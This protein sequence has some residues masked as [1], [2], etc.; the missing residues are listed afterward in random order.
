MNFM[1][2]QKVKFSKQQL[3]VTFLV[4]FC[5]TMVFFE[6]LV[7]PPILPLMAKELALS[8]AQAGSYMT[9]FFIGYFVSNL[10]GG[11]IT[12]RFGYKKT[13]MGVLFATGL[14]TGLMG[15]ANSY[16]MGFVIR[17]LS[18]IVAGAATSSVLRAV[19]EWFPDKGRGTAVGF[20][21]TGTSTGLLIVN[22]FIP[23]I[24]R[25]YGLQTAFFTAGLLNL[26]PLVLVWL[27][28]KDRCDE[29]KIAN[30]EKTKRSF[31][32]DMKILVKNKNLLI[33]GV[34]GFLSQ[35]ATWGA[36]TW[37][38]TQMNQ[39]LHLSLI[40]AG[41]FMS[42]YALA[43]IIIK[44]FSGILADVFAKKRKYLLSI[45]LISMTPVMIGFGYNTNPGLLY[46]LAPLL[47]MASFCFS[48]VMNI[49]IGDVVPVHLSGSATGFVNT[50]WQAGSI[51]S[52]LAVGL[53]LDMT[54][55]NYF[56]AFVF[57]GACGFFSGLSIL[58]MKFEDKTI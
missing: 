43:S 4:W 19:F 34:A 3:S 13:I 51:F 14:T 54:K 22:L 44:P 2:N 28:L 25:D 58:F 49:I 16:E 26:I 1:N 56:Y 23:V 12:D 9:A 48:P 8:A 38:N 46:I 50:I 7:I 10:P 24:A 31:V 37:A 33:L 39:V 40:E 42:M 21:V 41:A 18:G 52:P 27:F 45:M 29:N 15:F 35:A 5:Y 6:R 11:F 17:L 32:Q 47:G 30:T 53:I 55:N 36:A 20:L 57:L